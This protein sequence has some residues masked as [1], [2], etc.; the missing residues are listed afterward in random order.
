MRLNTRR[1]R[2]AITRWPEAPLAGIAITL[3][4]LGHVLRHWDD[5]HVA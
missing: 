2:D 1:L 3:I 5:A 4:G